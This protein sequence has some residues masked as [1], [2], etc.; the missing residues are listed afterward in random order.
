MH[1]GLRSDSGLVFT[2]TDGSPVRPHS[3]S[4]GFDRR[5]K[6]LGLP[7]IRFHNLRH[8]SAAT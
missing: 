1:T 5:I 3:V 7:R 8:T 4:Q 2:P 6:R